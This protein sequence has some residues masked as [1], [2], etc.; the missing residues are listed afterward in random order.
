MAQQEPARTKEIGFVAKVFIA[1]VIVVLF[2]ATWQVA[3]VFMLAFGGIVV[4][5]GLDNAASPLGRRLKLP[6]TVALGITVL[7][8]VW[9][10]AL[11]LIF[12]GAAA[13][14]QFATLVEELP[15]ALDD[16][17]AWLESWALGR[18]LLSISGD[19]LSASAS[20]LLNAI[21]IAGGVI[22][23][24]ANAAL[25]LVIGI[26]LAADPASYRKGFLRLLPPARR[27]RAEEILG[28][29]AV[30]LRKWLT[31][32]A[33]DMMFLGILTGFGLWLVGVPLS[34]A[35]G[36]LSGL[37]VFV[38]Y[39]GPIVAT[40]PGLIL[41]LSVSPDLA[42]YAGIVYIV[43]QQ[44][45][46]N[47]SLPL[48]QRWT[49]SMPPAVMLLAMVAFGLLFGLWGVLLATP[50]AVAAMTIIRMA[51]VEDVL[52]GPGSRKGG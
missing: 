25:M 33:L 18:W 9:V 16:A 35:L 14:A 13:T 2:L 38:P 46:G 15:A 27:D 22:G 20:T 4:A 50:L 1:V 6:R 36:V 17:E 19:A 28:A 3:S 49:V 37:S 24:L 23:G 39:I 47:I 48:L 29:T 31:A 51:Y 12:F 41:A 8:L 7:G 42:L 40:I 32:M 11:F 5:V 26:Y 43:A 34:F 44:L 30:N 45:E 52:E 21:P 10:T